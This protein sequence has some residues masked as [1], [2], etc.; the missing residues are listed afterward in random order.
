MR[1]RKSVF[2]KTDFWL[3]GLDLNQRPSGY[4]P[5]ELPAAPPRDIMLIFTALVYYN[6]LVLLLQEVFSYFYNMPLS[7]R[8]FAI[9]YVG[10]ISAFLP[11][12]L[13]QQVS[14]P[15]FIPPK[16]SE[17]TLSPTIRIFDLSFSGVCAST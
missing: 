6:T 1:Q 7:S 11:F 5:D 8:I 2:E 3:R 9:S 13:S 15:E 14:I 17:E 12:A 16:I 10:L 4:E